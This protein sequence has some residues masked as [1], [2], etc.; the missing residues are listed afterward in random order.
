[1]RRAFWAG[2][3]SVG[4]LGAGLFW[5]G[6]ALAQDDGDSPAPIDAP[7]AATA[8]VPAAKP[9]PQVELVIVGPEDAA[10]SLFGHAALRVIDSPEEHPDDARVFNFGITNFNRDNYVFDFVGGRV[11]FWGRI[12]R[13]ATVMRRWR[14]TDR[15]VTRFPVLLSDA[16]LRQLVAR[17]ERDTQPSNR[18]FVYDTFREN[19]ATRLRDYLDTYSHG[20]VYAKTGG[21]PSGRAF[22]QD[23][24]EAY[25]NVTA[26]L[27]GS[28]FAPGVEMDRP[29]DV[30]HMMYRPATLG[31]AL[32]TVQVDGRPLLG[33][34][35]VEYTRTGGD[36]LDGSPNHGQLIILIIAFLFGLFGW[37]INDRGGKA[38]GATLTGV[39]LLTTGFSL[40]LIWIA[41]MSDWPEMQRNPLVFAVLPLDIFLLWPA[42]QLFRYGET[43]HASI[44]RTYL[45]VRMIVG[46]VLVALTPVLTVL[47]GPLPPRVLGVVMAWVALRCLDEP[48]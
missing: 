3:L 33:P 19:C 26:I 24:R 22:R 14:R 6:V 39:S 16:A 1:M 21:V 10:F 35:I 11:K 34:G 2:L 15:T 38:R 40:L 29:R 13:W 8:E 12:E 36:P 44:A 46:L 28:E 43:G 4:L 20:A 42:F 9:A 41:W 31:S 7:I 5:P 23:V 25:S 18:D 17:M 30:W 48:V 27:L 32:Q 37:F 47:E 45:K